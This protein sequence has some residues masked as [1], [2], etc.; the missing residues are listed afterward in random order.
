MTKPLEYDE[1]FS[2]NRGV[3]SPEKQ[4]R[5]Q[6]A[7]VL[8]IGCGGIGGTVTTI[9]ARS[10]VCN[11]T[12]VDPDVFE[13]TNMN[14]QIGCFEDTL[15]KKKVEVI[16]GEILR[17]NSKAQVKALPEVVRLDEFN[18][19]FQEF[20]LVFP[21]ADDYAYSIMAFRGARNAG[22]PA[23]LVVPA[24]LWAIV[25]ILLP[26]GPTVE[27][28]HG[29]PS[30]EEY[31]ELKKL[32]VEKKYKMAASFYF[33]LGGWD[34]KYFRAFVEESAPVSQICPAVWLASSLGALE[35]TKLISGKEKPV[36]A[37]EYWLITKDGISKENTKSL[38]KYNLMVLQRK[39]AWK[40]LQG[41]ARS[42]QEKLQQKW[43]ERWR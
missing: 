7:R 40:M 5:L 36:I 2:R 15:G 38:N 23:L 30:I 33:S 9:L 20:D 29:V 26:D 35:V 28:I 4:A 22:K 18:S 21:A 17:I 19:W 11:F 1:L 13:P 8:V 25:T 41:P 12:L 14:R 32:F 37:P 34:K 39:A 6:N 3:L 10:G 16:K 42:I 31:E 24:G 43:W 27:Q